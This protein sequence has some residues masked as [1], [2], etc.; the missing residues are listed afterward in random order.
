MNLRKFLTLGTLAISV[1][2]RGHTVAEEAQASVVV[3]IAELEI[4]PAKIEN[5]KAAVRE[6]IEA[7]IRLET[8]VLALYSVA[9]K[10]A[11][12]H[13]R[14]FEIYGNEKAYRAHLESPHFRK[15]L[16]ITQSMIRSKRLIET[17]PIQLS[18]KMHNRE[19]CYRLVNE[20]CMR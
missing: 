9:E 2:G 3:R 11:P 19:L 13:L 20:R 16:T 14:F 1:L 15:Y 12:T 5:Y 8:G 10:D 6:E 18:T 17:V 4:D 7:S